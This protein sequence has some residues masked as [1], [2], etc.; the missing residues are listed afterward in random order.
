MSTTRKFRYRY[1]IVGFIIA[2]F[3]I[4]LILGLN[5]LISSGTPGQLL[6]EFPAAAILVSLIL[7]ISFLIGYFWG[8][9]RDHLA[10]IKILS[11][12][13]EEHLDMAESLSGFLKQG[14][15]ARRM[16]G[17]AVQEMKHPLT[18]IV[19]YSMTLREYWDKLDD[20][21][22]REFADYIEVSASRLEGIAN[23]MTRITELA[24][25]T[26]KLEKEELSL[27]DIAEEVQHLLEGI[28]NERRVKIGLRFPE[29]LPRM[30]S[31]PSRLFDLLYN[32]LDLCMRCSLD[33]KI[34]S[35]WCS[36]KERTALIRLRCPSSV[37]ESAQI[38]RLKVWPPPEADDELATLSM[39]FRL[40]FR[41]VEE[42]GGTLVLD[43]MGKNG[44]SFFISIPMN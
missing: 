8:A 2:V 19:G 23:D 21:S 9:E 7:P 36:Y 30:R 26:P 43:V 4:A 29:D 31:D 39:E 11:Q 1:A 41:M 34:V 3:Y 18:S 10:S 24:K 12:R 33:G 42:V 14:E 35:A 32:L 37:L 15:E 27:T 28:Y 38:R 22:R 17:I 44:M 16:I 13:Q 25:F 20:T 40:A 6:Q 5:Y